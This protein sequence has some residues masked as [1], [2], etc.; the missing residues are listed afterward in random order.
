[1]FAGYL[2]FDA[3]IANTDRHAVNWAMLDRE[4]AR[5]LAASFDHGS[6]LDSGSTPANTAAALDDVASWC[7]KGMATRFENGSATTLAEL[8]INAVA[9]AGGQ[10]ALWLSRMSA[11]EPSQ[12]QAI[13]HAV[14]GLSVDTHT[15]MDK[16]LTENQRRLCS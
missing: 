3:W 13:L 11:L 8:A 16:V 10:A 7:A 12:W 6:A 15:F 9:L 14:P 2:V 4:E 1:V 5:R